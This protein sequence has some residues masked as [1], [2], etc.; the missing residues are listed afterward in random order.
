M[1]HIPLW[2]AFFA[3]LLCGGLGGMAL[4]GVC[5]SLAIEFLRKHE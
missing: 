5:V 3:G 1:N 2:S 4:M